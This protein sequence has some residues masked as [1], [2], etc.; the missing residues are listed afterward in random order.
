MEGKYSSELEL[1]LINSM[2]K[3][4]PMENPKACVE[5]NK[6]TGLR[7]ETVSFQVAYKKREANVSKFYKVKLK[8]DGGCKA[9]LRQVLNVP[10]SFP[11]H[12]EID[13][14]YIKT[15][16]GLYPDLLRKPID[17]RVHA[18]V[19]QW[20]SLWIDVEI[21]DE[22]NVG[23]NQI[24]VE[25]YTNDG[26]VKYTD[27]TQTIDVFDVKLPKQQ[28]I[29]TEW[30]HSDCLADYYGVE[31][32]S[33]EHF[34]LIENFIAIAAKRGCN[35]ILTP[36]FTPPLDTAVGGQRTTVQLVEIEYINGTYNFNFDKLKRWIDIC[37][38][39]GIEYFEM[40]HLFT[41]WGAKCP[42]KIIANVDG[43]NKQIFGWEVSATS[44]EYITF[45]NAY[46][47]KL[48]VK[49]R[50]WG[51]ESTTYF[52]ISDEPSD[53]HLESYC[54]AVEIVREHLADFK[55]IDASSHIEFYRRG[56]IKKPICANDSIEPFLNANIEN[57]WTYYCTSQ[58]KDVSNRMIS[59]PSSRNRILGLQLF[60]YDIEGFLH[61]GYN[62][63]NSFESLFPIN[64]YQDTCA[65]GV[66][67]GG[68]PFLVYPGADGE[69]EESIRIMILSQGINDLRAC[70]LLSTKIGKQ[71][72]I[73][74][75]DSGLNQ[76]LTFSQYPKSEYWL[77]AIRNLINQRLAEI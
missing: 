32:F 42:P 41:Q 36:H 31:V 22:T 40:S 18:I 61:W 34:K 23:K 28:L 74:I 54:A 77:H 14:N 47:P 24:T 51:I 43:I 76:E 11:A 53:N 26:K 2:I 69:A 62:F 75:I 7:G 73:D 21:D 37:Q 66:F 20:Q 39:Q 33:D 70:Q 9:S 17:N 57:M 63:Y 5:L 68:D 48:T 72:V 4:F 60:K 30:F 15:T 12:N 16:P 38:K 71:A 25:F 29:H 1:K 67:P 56:L 49:L 64:P 44:E 50:E 19:N 6:L 8:T 52:H 58:K 35:M 65:G 45:L 55:I 46:L 3:V 13:D 59:M 10:V 27:I